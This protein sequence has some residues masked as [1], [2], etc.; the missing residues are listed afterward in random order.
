MTDDRS[1]DKKPAPNAATNPANELWGGRFAGGASDI[2]Q[3]INA[4]IYFDRRF[5]RQDI[6]G[7]R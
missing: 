1:E 6:A 2:M 4:S 5:Y 7:S 3:R